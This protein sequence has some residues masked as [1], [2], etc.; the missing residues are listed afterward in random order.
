M[1]K[2]I[3]G[4][5]M[6][7]WLNDLALLKDIINYKEIL[8]INPD[9]KHLNKRQKNIVKKIIEA[10]ERLE[11]FIPYIKKVFPEIKDG[12][13]ESSLIKVEKMKGFIEEYFKQEIRG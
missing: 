1:K 2:I 9:N 3:A 5:T 6:D 12:I 4:K 13:I 8:W 10:E 11:R 7:E